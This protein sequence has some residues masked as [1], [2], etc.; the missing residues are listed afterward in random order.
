MVRFVSVLAL[1]ALTIGLAAPG[2][3]AATPD[4]INQAIEDGLAWL[5]SVQAADGSW[6]GSYPVSRTGLAVLKFETH[7]VFMG[8]SPFDPGY[9]YSPNVIDGLDYLFSNAFP[10]AIAVQPAGNPDTN[11][12]GIGVY[13]DSPGLEHPTYETGIALMA[14]CA[15]NDPGRMVTTGSG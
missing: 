6:A 2:A 12:N 4:E 15:G 7:A 8:M 13:F 1:L 5:A 11:G 10:L 14:V 3:S 9:Q